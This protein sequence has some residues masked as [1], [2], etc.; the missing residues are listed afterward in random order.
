MARSSF[1]DSLNLNQFYN[2]YPEAMEA[3]E[4]FVC[5]MLRR[6]LG[7]ERFFK[8]VDTYEDLRQKSNQP[9]STTRF[10]KLTEDVYGETLDW[11]FGTTYFFHT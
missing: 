3:R 11:F 4:A 7:D 9:V 2:D 8:L 6:Q 10:R 5:H 1:P